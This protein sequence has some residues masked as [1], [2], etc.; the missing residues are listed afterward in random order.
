[1]SMMK[2]FKSFAMRGNV[3]DMAIGI[4]MG[5]AFGAIV[6]SLV[7]DVIMPPIGAVLGGIDFSKIGVTIKEA[8]ETAPA[9][10]MKW[11][12]FINTIITFIIVAFVM[13][14][15][16]KGMNAMKKKEEAAPATTKTC[17]ECQ[18]SIPINAKRCGHCTSVLTK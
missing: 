6:T 11:G 14:L 12:A 5:V 1:M 10:I 15:L 4:I 3:M 2:E 7:N 17:P 13:F 16:V 8:T 18:M 9:V